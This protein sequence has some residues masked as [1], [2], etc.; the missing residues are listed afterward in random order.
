M[1]KSAC[2]ERRKT[3]TAT[4]FSNFGRHCHPAN[5]Q[6]SWVAVLAH[7]SKENMKGTIGSST[8]WLLLSRNLFVCV[9]R[10]SMLSKHVLF[11]ATFHFNVAVLFEVH[12]HSMLLG[13]LQIEADEYFIASPRNSVNVPFHGRKFKSCV[14]N[15]KR[16]SS[17]FK[18]FINYG[19]NTWKTWTKYILDTDILEGEGCSP[20]TSAIK[21]LRLL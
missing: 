19:H 10:L 15:L 8:S 12:L 14:N 2:R 7:I 9:C 16:P 21:P 6:G 3:I 1:K 17:A 11:V 4:L 5:N 18:I 20:S 13:H